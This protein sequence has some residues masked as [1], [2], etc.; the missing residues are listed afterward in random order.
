M[1]ALTAMTT[2]S[3]MKTPKDSPTKEGDR[4]CHRGW[5]DAPGTV[6]RFVRQPSWMMIRWDDPD[7][8]PPLI[9]HQSELPGDR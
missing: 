9:C 6:M 8:H 5:P 7:H 3:P 4:V 2:R 1:K